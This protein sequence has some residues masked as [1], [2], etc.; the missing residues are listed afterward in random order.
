[1][2]GGELLGRGSEEVV[3]FEEDGR[4]PD[5]DDRGGV[6]VGLAPSPQDCDVDGRLGRHSIH[7]GT[8][9]GVRC[10]ARAGARREKRRIAGRVGCP[11][12]GRRARS[13]L[14]STGVRGPMSDRSLNA[15]LLPAAKRL[16]QCA[17]TT[18]SHPTSS[19]RNDR[20]YQARHPR[21]R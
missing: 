11:G 21:R 3:R 6:D 12:C 7:E 18:L 4:G 1:M 15:R 17:E 9:A 19:R 20:A 13:R 10:G 14:G 5:G 16:G 2:A 8:K